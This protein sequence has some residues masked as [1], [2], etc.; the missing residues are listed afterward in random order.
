MNVEELNVRLHT[1]GKEGIQSGRTGNLME[2]KTHRQLTN[3]PHGSSHG[4]RRDGPWPSGATWP[5]STPNDFTVKSHTP[6]HG[7]LVGV[8][9]SRP[10]PDSA[11]AT[12]S[13]SIRVW[14]QMR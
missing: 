11:S 1:T 3:E 10:S 4:R 8:A 7:A 14:K 9:L 2:K 13:R 6:R 5:G 12:K